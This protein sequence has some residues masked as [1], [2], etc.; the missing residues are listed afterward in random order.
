MAPLLSTLIYIIIAAASGIPAF[1]LP[2]EWAC[3]HSGRVR[4]WLRS[5]TENYILLFSVRI[6]RRESCCPFSPATGAYAVDEAHIAS[7]C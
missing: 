5:S 3:L 6:R 2:Q 7:A 1:M 4:H